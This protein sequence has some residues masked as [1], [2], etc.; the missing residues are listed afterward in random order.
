MYLQLLSKSFEFRSFLHRFILRRCH[1][2]FIQHNLVSCIIMNILAHSWWTCNSYRSVCSSQNVDFSGLSLFKCCRLLLLVHWTED[3]KAL[4]SLRIYL[5]ALYL[6]QLQGFRILLC[7][8]VHQ[9]GWIRWNLYLR[10]R[11]SLGISFLPSHGAE[12]ACIGILSVRSVSI[13]FIS[14]GNSLCF[15]IIWVGIDKLLE[16]LG[17]S[18][19]GCCVVSSRVELI[20]LGQHHVWFE[21]LA[22]K[23]F[24]GWNWCGDVL[25]IRLPHGSECLILRTH[26]IPWFFW[27]LTMFRE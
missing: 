8:F 12:P 21:W 25:H 3:M 14:P 22:L 6:K 17:Y 7:C 15:W 5:L 11:L 2:N 19:L 23:Y 18:A 10:W 27:F 13:R 9:W 4:V 1:I 24:L 16:L 26:R 20:T